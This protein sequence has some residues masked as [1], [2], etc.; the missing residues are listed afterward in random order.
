MFT[1]RVWSLFFCACLG[2]MTAWAQ[3]NAKP[4]AGEKEA[5]VFD[6]K[7]WAR[8]AFPQDNIISSIRYHLGP[9][10]LVSS[11]SDGGIL[12]CEP[13]AAIFRDTIVVAWNDSYGGFH[14]SRTGVAVGWAISRDR[15]KTFRFGGY[16]PAMGKGVLPSG[17]DSWLATDAKGNFYLQVLSWQEQSHHIQVYLMDHR[18]LGKW[19]QMTDAVTSDRTKSGPALDKPAM[20]VDE[21]GRI[22]IAYTAETEGS[23]ISFVMSPDGGERWTKPIAVSARS[24]KLKTGAAVSMHGNRIVVSW[25]EGAGLRLGEVWYAISVNGGRSFTEPF[26][27]YRLK[28]PLRP[29]NGYALGVGP[30]GFISNNIWLA[31]T[32]ERPDKTTFYLAC[33]EGEGSGSRILLFTLAPGANTWSQPTQIRAGGS[34][35]INFFPSL[36]SMGNRIAVLYYY[37]EEATNTATDVYLSIL[38]GS[39]RFEILKLNAVSTI[40]AKV[41]GDR[42]FAPVQRNFGDYITLASY[43]NTLVATWTD[44]RHDAP[45]IYARTIEI[46][47]L[48][49]TR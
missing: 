28:E 32:S 41:A 21:A 25:M 9:E 27:P 47:F 38:T 18:N 43:E 36:S 2:T 14:G 6:S 10:I 29:P 1:F 35:S 11:N 30:A 26:M 39:E 3:E 19:K 31:Y 34:G 44:G 48:D 23:T 8:A 7:K 40:W 49:S 22:A 15:G 24:A 20:S 45:R 16:L 33:T 37:R 12:R 42:Q 5:E 17:A 13:S 46:T 4:R